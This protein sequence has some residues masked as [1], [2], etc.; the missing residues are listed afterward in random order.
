[1]ASGALPNA[2]ARTS[3]QSFNHGFALKMSSTA[4][5]GVSVAGHDSQPTSDEM[6]RGAHR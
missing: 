6:P 1:M 2:T 3:S 5:I 4:P